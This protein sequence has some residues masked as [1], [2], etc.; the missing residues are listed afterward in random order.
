AKTKHKTT[1]QIQLNNNPQPLQQQQLSPNPTNLFNKQTTMGCVSSHFLTQEED[2]T[3]ISHHIV[4]LTSTT[5]GLLT[6]DPSSSPTT[7]PP[8][9]PTRFTLGSFLHTPLTEPIITQPPLEVIDS[10]EL[11]AGLEHTPVPSPLVV[12]APHKFQESPNPVHNNR[13]FSK[14]G[15]SKPGFSDGLQE[16]PYPDH[17]SPIFI[18]P[19]SCKR[20]LLDGFQENANPDHKNRV[21]TK[22]G[23]CK[24]VFLD[25]LTEH[26]NPD[27]KNRVCVKPGSDKPVLLDGFQEN[28]NPDGF[29][30]TGNRVFIKPGS[31]KPVFL[32]GFEELCPPKGE[33]RVVIYTTSLRGVRKTFE[34]CNAVRA[35]LDGY[36]VTYC[37][38]DISMDRGF[39]EE[40]RELM[41]GKNKHELVPPRVFVK[42]RYVG[43]SDEVLR[44]VEEGCLG[45]LLEGLPKARVGCVC[46]VCGGA[47]MIDL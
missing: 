12:D 7:I 20:V 29:Q 24:P 2:F 23:S 47:R 10:L 34:A 21:F 38:R 6:L 1:F 46:E 4:S 13:V 3:Q 18:R 17:K 44:I 27:E 30:E 28:G 8:T 45:K 16:N 26:A 40:L 11:M 22:P 35:V 37:E 14:P 33:N 39:K 25:G 9:P 31:Y 15:F 19:G 43:G 32:D 42:G 36:G 41:K 5:Y